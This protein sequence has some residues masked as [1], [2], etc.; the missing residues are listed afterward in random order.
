MNYADRA[1]DGYLMVGIVGK[2]KGLQGQVRIRPTT[3]DPD[4]FLVLAGVY[5]RVDGVYSRAVFKEITVRNGEVLAIF[6][7]HEDRTAA[8]R[9]TGRELFVP[10]AEAIPLKNGQYYIADLIGCE[11]YNDTGALIG[12]LREVMQSGAADVYALQGAQGEVLFPA[13]KDVLAQVDVQ[14]KRIV[15]NT[16]RFNEVAVFAH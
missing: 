1:P 8:E 15:V 6:A 12:T 11:V 16:R 9:L 13:L 7:G 4:R 5:W 14:A 10:R 3:D 2:A